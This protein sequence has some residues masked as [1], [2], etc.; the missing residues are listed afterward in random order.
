MRFVEL[1][2]TAPARMFGLHPKKGT[3]A[4]GSD[5]D[6]VV[7]DPNRVRTISAKTHHMRVDYS[8]Y[9]GREV[10]GSPEVVLQRGN[11]LVERGEFFG[12]PGDGRFL[13]RRPFSAPSLLH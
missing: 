7:F 13:E 12:K 11:V 1:V 8:C 3:I 5:A 4:P 6:V 10:T 2:A 9:E